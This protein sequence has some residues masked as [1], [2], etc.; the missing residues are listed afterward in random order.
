[1]ILYEPML[2]PIKGNWSASEGDSA[3][4]ANVRRKAAPWMG[5]AEMGGF[6]AYLGLH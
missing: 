6:G 4:G 2:L 3:G 5:H 1:M